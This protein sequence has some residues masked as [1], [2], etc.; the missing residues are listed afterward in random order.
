MS[1]TNPPPTQPTTQ[2][3]IAKW[4]FTP[5]N[6]DKTTIPN[7][8]QDIKTRKQRT[9]AKEKHKNR[10]KRRQTLLTDPLYLT[11]QQEYYGDNPYSPLPSTHYHLIGGNINGIPV[12]RSNDKNRI[13]FDFIKKTQ[14]SRIMISEPNLDPRK[15]RQRQGWYE[16]L[17]DHNM[18]DIK[19]SWAHNRQQKPSD[20]LQPGGTMAITQGEMTVV[21][22]KTT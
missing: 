5:T 21:P 22:R 20:L 2:T 1:P 3:W 14:S 13:L 8:L 6:H 19:T 18:R 17:K 9:T 4:G 10:R 16:R 15:F 7:H 12:K 11:K